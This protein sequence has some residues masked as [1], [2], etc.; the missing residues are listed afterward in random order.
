ME[1]HLHTVVFCLVLGYGY[2]HNRHVRVDFLR[3]N[4]TFKSKAKVE[5]YGNIVVYVTFYTNL[6]L[7]FLDIHGGFICY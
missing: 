3:E 1:W 2:T 6:C 7:F 5:F 4:F